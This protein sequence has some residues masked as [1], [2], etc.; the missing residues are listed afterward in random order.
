MY[1]YVHDTDEM[2][3]HLRVHIK[4]DRFFTR[5]QGPRSSLLRDQNWFAVKR[6][7]RQ[8]RLL[9]HIVPIHRLPFKLF[10]IRVYVKKKQK[11]NAY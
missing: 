10:Q 1:I 5:R 8:I 6:Y 9:F 4:P 11:K 7:E 2:Q 3:L